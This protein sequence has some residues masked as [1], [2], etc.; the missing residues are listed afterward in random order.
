MLLWK[1]YVL[2]RL[3]SESSFGHFIYLTRFKRYTL[4]VYNLKRIFHIVCF[5]FAHNF[6]GDFMRESK[7]FQNLFEHFNFN[8]RNLFT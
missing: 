8:V 2:C 5:K 3:L 4:E 7:S 6:L 1:A